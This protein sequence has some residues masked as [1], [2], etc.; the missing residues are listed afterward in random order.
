VLVRATDRDALHTL[1]TALSDN[2][3]LGVDA[4]TEAKYYADMTSS[5]LPLEALGMFVAAIMAVGSAFGAMN[6][7][8]A[9]VARR[10]REI[11]TLRALGFSRFSILR[12]FFAESVLLSLFGGLLG[13]LLTLPL[14]RITTGVGSFT[15]F[16]E[17]AFNFHVGVAAIAVGLVFAASIGAVGGFLPAWAASRRNLLVAMRES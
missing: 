3:R 12:S 13:C 1:M 14:N 10:G 15:T 17:V 11:A 6:T 9:A 5:G 2:Q 4:Q 7:M 8:Y 16:S